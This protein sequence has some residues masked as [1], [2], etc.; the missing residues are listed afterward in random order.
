MAQTTPKGQ[1][2]PQFSA[3]DA[4][5]TDWPQVRNRLDQAEV[6]WLT[7]VRPDGRPHVTPLIGVCVDDTVHFCTGPDERKA[8]NLAA[9]QQ[10]VL[11]TGT[12]ALGEGLD[13][14]VEGEAVKITDDARLRRLAAAWEA[15]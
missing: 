7:T 12:N 9:N 4:I 5:A 2:D 14:V 6:Y 3:E 15:K 8:K 10:V 11:T 13:V 1:L